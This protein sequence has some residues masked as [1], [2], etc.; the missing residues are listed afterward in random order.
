MSENGDTSDHGPQHD[1][2]ASG[3]SGELL[4]GGSGVGGSGGSGRDMLSSGPIERQPRRNLA[5]IVVSLVAVLAVIGG[6]VAYVGYHKLASSGAQPDEWAPASSI[7]YVKIDLDPA[8]SEKVAALRFEQKFPDAPH[9]TSA[10]QLK[11]ALLS[12]AFAQPSSDI[13]YA[14]DIKPWL[15]DRVALAVYP[16][17]SGTVQTVGILQVKDATQAQAGLT[18]LI[19]TAGGGGISTAGFAIENDYAIVGPSQ[20]V[21]DAA[22]TAART[23]SITASSQY[24][25]DVATLGG[26]RIVTAWADLGAAAK[27]VAK[28][29][30]SELSNLSALSALGAVSSSG[31]GSDSA[32]GGDSGG[33]ESLAPTSVIGPTTISGL[34]QLGGMQGL[35]NELKGRLVL[36]LSLQSGY[37]EISGRIVGGDVSGIQS[38][39]ADA[40]ALLGQL[41]AGSVGGVAVSGIGAAISKELAT[42]ESGPL[43]SLGLKDELDAASAQLGI[44]LPGDAVNLVGNGVAIGLDSV[45]ADG[46]KAKFTGISEP[47]DVAKGLKTAQALAGL[48]STNGYAT[49]ATASGSKIVVTND[50]GASGTLSDDPG[51]QSAMSGMPSQVTAA[52]YVD[53]AGIWP[54]LGTTKVPSD[55]QH[56]T[57]IGTYEAIDGSDITFSVRVTVN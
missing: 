9:V 3:L 36:G 8:A 15:G 7:A 21:V 54:S 35:T 57:G 5:A 53:L 20:A 26:D 1:D 43:A 44:S 52:A 56:L 49:T 51:F 16:D 13:D 24:A 25:A 42:L 14:T 34:G 32:S 48:L 18:K 10:D 38:Q 29:G 27:Y 47:T 50:A 19:H 12:D 39:N 2:A 11:D 37:A 45:P 33:L 28:A 30:A 41:P 22:V 6:G 55:I 31:S 17:A 40:G 23:S 46:A 4:S